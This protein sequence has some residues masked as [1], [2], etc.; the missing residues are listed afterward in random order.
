VCG[1][2]EAA[3]AGGA[4]GGTGGA[5][6]PGP[7]LFASFSLAVSG[8]T[9]NE[10]LCDLG[11]GAAAAA[12][13]EPPEGT[14]AMLSLAAGAGADVGVSPVLPDPNPDSTPDMGDA[15]H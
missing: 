11:P 7:L 5:P 3:V 13:V 10:K 9:I 6:E 4:G 1:G 8:D 14:D 12:A 15:A 2:A